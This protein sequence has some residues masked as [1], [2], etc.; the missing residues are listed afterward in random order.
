MRKKKIAIVGAGNAG[1]M[2]ALHSYWN[3][4][5]LDKI[6]I[7]HDPSIPLE[8]VGQG[9]TIRVA[10][11]IFDTLN[12]DFIENN[13]IKATVKHGIMYENWGKRNT[14]HNFPLNY[15]GC[16]Y[17]PNLLSKT[18]LES[19]LFEVIERKI[20][21]TETEIDADFVFDCRGKTQRGFKDKSKKLVNP[22]NT[23]LLAKKEG[24]DVN[25]TYT[26]CVA[27]PNGW[28]F[29]IPNHDSVSYGYLYNN[30]I[31]KFEDAKKNFIDLFEVDPFIDISFENYIEESMWSGKKTILNGNRLSFLEPLEAA[32]TAFYMDTA[33]TA[34]EHIF[35]ERSKFDCNTEVQKDMKKIETFVLWHYQAGSK[36]NTPFWKHAKELQFNPDKTFNYIKNF[37][38]N[39][40]HI[41]QWKFPGDYSQWPPYSFSK[42][43]KVF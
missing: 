17:I 40:D 35:D 36:F 43:L 41:E 6:T 26:R 14:F 4:D 37:V 15:V 32:S 8:M 13:P 11:L 25:L 22:L 1:C 38:E 19:N 20:T 16:H 31:T 9:T 7:Y 34:Y 29:V 24:R 3:R 23:V 10:K 39:N 28:T 33:A 5:K 21:D 42:W 27:T 2:T 30:T 18:V 12:I